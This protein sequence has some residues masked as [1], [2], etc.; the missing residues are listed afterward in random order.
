MYVLHMNTMGLGDRDDHRCP[1]C[2]Q[3]IANA[4]LIVQK[5][6]TIERKMTELRESLSK[7][8]WIVIENATGIKNMRK[9]GLELDKE[10]FD[11]AFA[12]SKEFLILLETIE[13]NLN[14]IG[15]QYNDLGSSGGQTTGHV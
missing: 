2:R 14:S 15:Q 8:E 11:V 6:E 10:S 12:Q 3:F 7:Y 9:S 5:M 1:Q 13:I 4:D